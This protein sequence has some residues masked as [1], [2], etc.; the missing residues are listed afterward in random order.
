M[1]I[2]DE[3]ST[4]DV[5]ITDDDAKELEYLL[6]GT[7]T[8]VETHTV[9]NL[10]NMKFRVLTSQELTIS[11]IIASGVTDDV[12][13]GARSIQREILW[14]Y[15]SIEGVGRLDGPVMDFT[16]DKND[17]NVMTERIKWLQKWPYPLLSDA[18][19]KYQLTLQHY[20]EKCM[21]ENVKNLQGEPE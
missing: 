5:K 3:N 15:Y 12:A 1:P 19:K 9:G 18:I 8:Y 21:P 10:F 6:F 11:D 7:E 20:A 4:P 2:P 16:E 13:I 17:E 14:L